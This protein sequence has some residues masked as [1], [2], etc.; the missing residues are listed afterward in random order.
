MKRFVFACYLIFSGLLAPISQAQDKA[1]TSQ[2][3]SALTTPISKDIKPGNTDDGTPKNKEGNENANTIVPAQAPS[4]D[5]RLA[6]IA[7]KANEW[8]KIQTYIN[9]VGLFL[10][11]LTTGFALGAWLAARNGMKVTRDIGQKQTKAYLSVKSADLWVPF[12]GNGEKGWFSNND[13]F[14][15][16]LQAIFENTG[17]TPAHNVSYKFRVRLFGGGE[18]LLVSDFGNTH[19]YGI[20]G[21]KR[22]TSGTLKYAVSTEVPAEG[23]NSIKAIAVRTCYITI[24]AE[25]SDVFDNRWYI[26]STFEGAPFTA[27]GGIADNVKDLA[28]DHQFASDKHGKIKNLR[29]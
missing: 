14:K 7:R 2:E 17:N 5:E 11:F 28:L 20:V 12:S 29:R 8:T 27:N 26:E 10:L 22:D 24:R 4:L 25:Y 18:N 15:F 1:A 13:V 23:A 16:T 3:T 6:E 19:S 9:G 21:H